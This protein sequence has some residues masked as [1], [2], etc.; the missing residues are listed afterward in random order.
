MTRALA[1]VGLVG[2]NLADT[3]VLTGWTPWG[4]LPQPNA[5]FTY[6]AA[7]EDTK[8]WAIN[9]HASQV[10]LTHYSLFCKYLGRAYAALAREWAEGHRLGAGRPH[11]GEDHILG[12]ELFQIESFDPARLDPHEADPIQIA[13]AALSGKGSGQWPVASGQEGM[14]HGP[15]AVG[16][17]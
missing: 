10:R 15:S 6:D 11:R 1:A 7:A 14:D 2:A 4:P 5:F 3:L 13:L 12:V 17:V 16:S 9:C 8:T